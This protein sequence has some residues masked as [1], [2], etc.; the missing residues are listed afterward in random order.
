[1]KR[2]VKYNQ[3]LRGDV[4]FNET[5]AKMDKEQIRYKIAK[6]A[7]KEVSNGMTVNLGIGIPTLLPETV[8][9]NV[10]IDIQS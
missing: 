9:D 8:P 10:N 4:H 3:L 5:P 2:K 7:A 1:M 6:R